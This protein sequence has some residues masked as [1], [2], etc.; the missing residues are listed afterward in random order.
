MR[1]PIMTISGDT[2]DGLLIY[3]SILGILI[4]V[5]TILRLK[6][7]LLKKYY[8]PASLLAGIIGLIL[9]PYFV[10][11]IP[12]EIT[13]TWSNLSGKLIVLVFAPMLMGKGKKTEGGVEFVKK[14]ASSVSWSYL[15]CFVQYAVPLLMAVFLL[16]PVFHVPELF[17]VIVEAGW[18]GGHGTAAGMAAVYEEI[19]WLEGQSLA[20]T[21][22]TFGLVYGILG[23]VVLIPLC[24]FMDRR[25]H[26]AEN[27]SA[28]SQAARAAER[29]T[30]I[31]GGI[32]CGLALCLASNFQQFGIQYTTV[33]KAGFITACYIVIVPVIG[34]FFGKKCSPLMALAVVL[35]LAGLYLLCMT[36]GNGGINRGDILVLICA[37]LFSIHIM[38][39]DH[40]SPMVDGVKM[41]CIQFFVSGILSGAGMLLFEEPQLGRILEA[42][43]PI[44]YAGIMSCGVAY[45]LQIVGQKGV[46]PTVASL[47]LS[48]ES[49]ISV[50]A[51]WAILGQQLSSREILGCV[52]MF[53]AII[54]AQIPV[55]E[56][57]RILALVA[58]GRREQAVDN[59]ENLG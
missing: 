43:M 21:S 54:L 59:T 29:K 52:L 58:K 47:I 36:G 12:T 45:T 35:S 30:L 20:V 32:C 14:V 48:L 27:G 19:G 26:A 44:L 57:K 55:G 22:A 51:G 8:I 38:V 50:L 39:I 7:P 25:K 1:I 40:F 4:L 33:G 2:I 16:V 18:A 11:V 56:K 24:L 37:F 3:L 41:S 9:G 10:G 53:G 49:S 31:T 6:I 46:N 28:E 34:L 13:S 5:A 17:G 15:G 23:G 42:W